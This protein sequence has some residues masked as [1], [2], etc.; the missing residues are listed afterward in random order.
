[1][2]FVGTS[3]CNCEASGDEEGLGWPPLVEAR[4]EE[5][6][7]CAPW[8]KWDPVVWCQVP[9]DGGGKEIEGRVTVGVARLEEVEG[10]GVDGRIRPEPLAFG[11]SCFE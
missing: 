1:M 10:I 11:I 8:M 7:E 6:E 2:S 5:S 9:D 3:G 4:E